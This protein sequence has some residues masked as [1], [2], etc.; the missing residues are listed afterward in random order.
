[1]YKVR[2]LLDVELSVLT[3]NVRSLFRAS[4]TLLLTSCACRGTPPS[5]C[6]SQACAASPTLP[7]RHCSRQWLYTS[8][9]EGGHCGVHTASPSSC[10]ARPGF[11][12]PTNITASVLR[13][14][15]LR[16]GNV[17]NRMILGT[18]CTHMGRVYTHIHITVPVSSKYTV[19]CPPGANLLST[20]ATELALNTS[21][22]NQGV[23]NVTEL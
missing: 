21:G 20:E 16:S 5:R 7:T 17:Y 6:S 15:A 22:V 14:W 3:Y 19:T 13:A 4:P 8:R 23:M 11:P 18:P 12:S 2:V 1:M 9:V 10:N